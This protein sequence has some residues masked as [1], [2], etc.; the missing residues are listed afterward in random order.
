MNREIDI[1]VIIESYKSEVAELTHKLIMANA[2]IKQQE[3]ELA[4]KQEN[5]Q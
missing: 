2:V 5:E 4:E 3:Q 1:N